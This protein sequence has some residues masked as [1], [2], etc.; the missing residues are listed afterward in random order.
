MDTTFLFRKR[1]SPSTFSGRFQLARY[2][3]DDRVVVVWK[4]LMYSPPYDVSPQ[5]R[6]RGRGWVVIKSASSEHSSTSIQT[7]A[8]YYPESDVA[9]DWTP[10]QAQQ[11]ANIR[12]LIEFVTCAMEGYS[13]LT[14]HR[15]LLQ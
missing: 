3:T 15:S 5:V 14:T 12:I 2:A 10:E 13:E 1:S 7:F 8:R 9:D 11:D 6:L 4:S